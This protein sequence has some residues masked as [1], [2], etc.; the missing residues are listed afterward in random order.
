MTFRKSS[1]AP[2]APGPHFRSRMLGLAA[3]AATASAERDGANDYFG[4]LRFDDGAGGRSL[5]G[6]IESDDAAER[7]FRVGGE[8]PPIGSCLTGIHRNAAGIGVLDDDAGVVLGELCDAFQRCVGVGNI[9]ERQFLALHLLRA[10]DAGGAGGMFRV[11]AAVGVEGR[12]LVGVFAV[13][14]GLF[15]AEL[16]VEGA[17]EV[18]GAGRILAVNERAEV[19]GD[20]AVVAGRV[21]E[22]FDRQIKPHGCGN[23]AFFFGAVARAPRHSRPGPPPRWCPGGF[24]AAARSIAGPPMSMLSMACSSLQSGSATVSSNG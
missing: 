24:L 11:G 5:E 13:A 16:Q 3:T 1:R 18:G 8:G 20:G 17:G 4:K 15:F 19:V 10:G 21:F 12:V 2:A 7:G 6:L 14:H 22:G 9:V 23:A